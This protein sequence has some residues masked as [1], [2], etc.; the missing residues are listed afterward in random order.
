M[1]IINEQIYT[2]KLNHFGEDDTFVS[3]SLCHCFCFTQASVMLAEWHSKWYN[4]KLE[5]K[6]L[7]NNFHVKSLKLSC[8]LLAM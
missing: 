8:G 5:G 3:F 4:L 2:F 7:L 6:R 1:R